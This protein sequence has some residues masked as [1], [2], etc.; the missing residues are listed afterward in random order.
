MWQDVGLV[1]TR[2]GLARAVATLAAWRPI[3]NAARTANP[4]DPRLRSLASLVTV[5]SLIAR[6]ARRREESR[7]GHFR[8]DFPARDDIN[9]NRHMADALRAS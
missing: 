2:E 4:G 9:W 3:V 8:E 7:G 5:G 1:R 6:A